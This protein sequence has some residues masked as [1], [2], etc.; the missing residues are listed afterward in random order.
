MISRV[1]RL[2]EVAEG[3]WKGRGGEREGEG[4]HGAGRSTPTARVRQDGNR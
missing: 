4:I 2:M 1:E 3:V